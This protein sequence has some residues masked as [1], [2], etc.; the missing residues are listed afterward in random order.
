MGG[1]VIGLSMSTAMACGRSQEKRILS[2]AVTVS[3]GHR[4]RPEEGQGLSEKS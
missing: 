1:E 4:K 3:V 2:L